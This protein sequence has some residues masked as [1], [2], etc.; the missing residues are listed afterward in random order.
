MPREN[1][2]QG[3][4]LMRSYRETRFKCII[5]FN[6]MLCGVSMCEEKTECVWTG[7]PQLNLVSQGT[8]RGGN[9]YLLPYFLLEGTITLHMDIS[10]WGP[11][12]MTE[13]KSSTVGVCF[14]ETRW[15][16]V[17][18]SFLFFFI[19][20]VHACITL[21]MKKMYTFCSNTI[22]FSHHISI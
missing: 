18:F 2:Q 13:Y 6:W 4:A 7:M 15:Y 8:A 12:V 21:D 5:I 19:H 14:H 1:I 9:M 3:A 11:R 22:F 16:L 10:S 17:L 20:F